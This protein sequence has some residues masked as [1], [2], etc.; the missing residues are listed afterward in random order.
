M[1]SIIWIFDP[2][3]N[4]SWPFYFF[5]LEPQLV[6]LTLK[7]DILVWKAQIILA[8]SIIW[9]LLSQIL[10]PISWWLP[11]KFIEAFKQFTSHCLLSYENNYRANPIV[12]F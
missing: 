7:K 8:Y 11:T 3:S 9:E 10:W 4:L 12:F 1:D 6:D 2:R 5:L